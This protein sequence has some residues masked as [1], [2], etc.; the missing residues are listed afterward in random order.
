MRADRRRIDALRVTAAARHRAARRSRGVPPNRVADDRGAPGAWRRVRRG[1]AR[2]CR[3]GA[4]LACAFAPLELVVARAALPRRADLAVARRAT[5]ARRRVARFLLRRRALFAVGTWWLY[6]CDPRLRPGADLAGAAADGARWSLI[7]ARLSGAA[8]LVRRALAAARRGAWRWLLAFPPRGCSSNG[9]AA[10]SCPAFRGCRWA[11]RRRHLAG[12]PRAGRR[13]LPAERAG[14]V[15]AA[16]RWSRW[17]AARAAAHRRW[18]SVR[19]CCRGRWRFALRDVEWTQPCGAPVDGGDAAGR[20]SAGH[21]MARSQSS[22]H[23]LDDYYAS[24][25]ATRSARDLIVWPESALPDLANDLRRLY[26]RVWSQAQRARLGRA[27]G[28]AC[29]SRT[30]AR[31]VTSTRCW[32]WAQSEPAFYDKHHL[33]PFRRILPGAATSCATGCG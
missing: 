26:R 23:I 11:I 5:R 7:M 16:A 32:R 9:G 27:D 24:C 14:A 20:G 1:R 18:R 8:G 19:W 29:A 31:R 33:V 21:E 12:R 28:R 4:L 17:C 6:I 22:T 25:I 15:V 3:S 2:C 13:R 30:T 10:G